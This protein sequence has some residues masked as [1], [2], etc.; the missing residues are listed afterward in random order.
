[1]LKIYYLIILFIFSFD[2]LFAAWPDVYCEWLPWCS[3]NSSVNALD[4][5]GKLVAELIKYVAV[6]AVIALIF[7]WFMYMFSWWNEEKTKKA[8]KWII[9][10]LV[11]VFIS[12]SWYYLIVLINNA[13]IKL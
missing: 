11:A 5:I 1:M 7:A 12:I 3:S 4:F 6:A 8:M 13:N 9:W 10:S 2:N